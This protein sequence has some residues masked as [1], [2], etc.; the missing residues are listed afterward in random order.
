M[1]RRCYDDAV[2]KR[3]HVYVLLFA[4]PALLLSIIAAAVMLAVSAGMFWLFVFG[5]DPWPPIAGSLLG[6]V[7]VLGGAALWLALLTT[8]WAVGKRQESRP[9]LNRAHVAVAI[10][11]TAVLAAAIAERLTGRNVSGT[12][13]DSLVCADICR[14]KGFMGSGMPPRNSG[15][16]TC[17]CYDAQG[18]EAERIDLSVA[19]ARTLAK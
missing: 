18:R 19:A 15:D 9:A 16:R 13:N 3:R 8:A 4:V 2:L 6:A 12:R 11:V 14:D 5:D 1:K 7:F 10:G 17:S